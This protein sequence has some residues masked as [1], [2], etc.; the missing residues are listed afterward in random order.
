MSYQWYFE[1]VLIPGA[2][3]YFYVAS[4]G[5]NYNV[6]CTDVN[7]CEVEAAIFDVIAKIQ[8]A[9]GSFRF[10]IFPNP[11]KDYIITRLADVNARNTAISF[12]NTLGEIVKKIEPAADNGK[13]IRIDISELPEGVYW[14]E[15][16]TEKNAMCSK[17]IKN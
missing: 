10:A 15:M 14:I 5:G 16:K 11:A 1:G 4:E 12:Y 6:V 17:L 13:E 9:D 7:G 2:T 3:D 8:L